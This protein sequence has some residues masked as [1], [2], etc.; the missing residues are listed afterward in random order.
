MTAPTL[1]ITRQEIQ[2]AELVKLLTT[3][4]A[5]A[6]LGVSKRT[7]QELVTE[8]K[9]GFIKFGRNI[10][11]SPADIERFIESHRTLPVGWKSA[12]NREGARQ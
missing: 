12:A 1:D 8:R 9:L 7:I 10:R 4:E 11:F 2:T 6:R 5:A 3:P